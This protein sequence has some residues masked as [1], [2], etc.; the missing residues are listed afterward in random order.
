MF[1]GLHDGL[2]LG[3]RAD[4]QGLV[5]VLAVWRSDWYLEMKEVEAEA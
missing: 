5:V 2:L 1:G 3:L 4:V